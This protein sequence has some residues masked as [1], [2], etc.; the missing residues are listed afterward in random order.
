MLPP[1]AARS[2]PTGTTHTVLV[3]AVAVALG[4]A[5]VWLILSGIERPDL[6]G[7]LWNRLAGIATVSVALLLALSAS[8]GLGFRTSRRR[9]HARAGS[10]E[11][12]LH[13]SE[14]R[15]RLAT[16]TAHLRVFDVDVR[17]GGAVVTPDGG[18]T[19]AQD[20]SLPD[21]TLATW[22]DP[23]HP[24]DREFL[25]AAFRDHKSG[26]ADS[27][28]AE[29]RRQTPDGRWRWVE[30]RS[31]VLTRT[32]AGAPE[33]LIGTHTDITD[34]KTA[35]LRAQRFANLH[36]AQNE[37][38]DAVAQARTVDELFGRVCDAVVSHRAVAMAW[39]G[40]CD[41]A[42]ARVVPLV[43]RGD[44]S[45]Y[46]SGLVI[47]T[48]PADPYGRGPVGEA[49]RSGRSVWIDDFQTRPETAP[50]HERARV[51]GWRAV[52]ALPIVREGQPT[53]VLAVYA[54]A[55]EAFDDDARA[56]LTEIAHTVGLGLDR[57]RLE[58]QRESVEAAHRASRARYE[59]LFTHAPIAVFVYREGRIVMANEAC[60]ELFGYH[61][62]DQ[63]IGQSPLAFF[64]PTE[65]AD[66]TS[67]IAR[68]LSTGAASPPSPRRLRRP[69]GQFRHVEV[70]AAPFDEAGVRSVHVALV[71]VTERFDA[72]SQLEA[73]AARYRTL[74]EHSPV[75]IFVNRRDRIALV[76]DA[77]LRLF[78]A[79]TAEELLG[80]SP[81][82]LLPPDHHEA[83]RA[84]VLALQEGRQIASTSPER[85]VR[86]DGQLV[87]VE[88]F[89][90]AFP[91]GETRSIHVSLVDVTERNRAD[92][93]LRA[94]LKEKD[95][96]LKE[97]HHRV[98][99]N[100]QVISSLL[101]LESGRSDDANV[102]AVLG[103]MQNRILSMAL[104]HETLYRGSQFADVHLDDYLRALT[105][106]LVR[107]MSAEHD[108]ALQL[109]LA[110]TIISPAQAIPCGLLVNELVSNA[111][112][113]GRPSD[114]PGQVHVGLQ[115]D[116]EAGL[117][118][119]VR[120]N[121][122]GLPADFDQRRAHSLGLQLVH[123]LT[124]QLGGRVSWSN[125]GGAAFV[126]HF[127]PRRGGHTPATT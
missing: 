6:R 109:D 95:A 98:K 125:D 31:R 32:A 106:Q 113:H 73:T 115:P 29:Y 81:F 35:E 12:A 83:I 74:V 75:A 90:A 53:D 59:N 69:N 71:D 112:K 111:L 37:C 1:S 33:R 85:I 70:S 13:R 102:Q 96:L 39:I 107:T 17:T 94:S 61:T 114:G 116:G 122:P 88:I 127:T 97:V 24:D 4:A 18:D 44:G 10:L 30:T 124:R 26:R 99:N 93:A 123:D 16:T 19:S 86:I 126:I 82:E 42:T 63:L 89:A 25:V 50:W 60:V 7:Q 55:A 51:A 15:L 22:F 67:R 100:L 2:K 104:L 56:I 65:Q 108:T 76:N 41:P 8:L 92:A 58:A 34:R 62:A 57:L 68:L 23:V 87:D 48:D 84:R 9:V 117:R 36:V 54:P 43:S 79:E 80:R 66:I 47:S 72:A 103:D 14:E 46:M 49:V 28:V 27:F 64:D 5:L 78:G 3:A 11:A 119:V 20:A 91:D 110:P 101:R 40:R 120:D 77:C 21:D 118:L 121:G 45:E 105:Q 52:A 38:S